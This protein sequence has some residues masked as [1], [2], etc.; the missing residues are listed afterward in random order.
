M[1]IKPDVR[2]QSG[3]VT[4]NSVDEPDKPARTILAIMVVPFMGGPAFVAL[5]IPY[6]VFEGRFP[7][8]T[9]KIDNRNNSTKLCLRVSRNR[10]QFKNH[11]KIF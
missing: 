3:H 2:Y 8:R 9:G 7:F 5:R 6:I 11:P 1:H 10:G 4:G